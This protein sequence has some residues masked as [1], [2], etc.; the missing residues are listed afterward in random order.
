[1]MPAILK[2]MRLLFGFAMNRSEKIVDV[3]LL[4]P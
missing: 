4:M 3:V 2:I 1:M